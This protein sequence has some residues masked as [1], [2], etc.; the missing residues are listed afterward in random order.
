MAFRFVRTPMTLND[1][2]RSKS[3]QSPVTKDYFGGRNVLL[4]LVLLIYS[5]N[6]R[7]HE[8]P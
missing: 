6:M 4:M 7:L 2:E 5:L 1:F 8:V 3:M